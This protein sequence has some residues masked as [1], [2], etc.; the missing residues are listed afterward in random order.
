MIAND[1]TVLSPPLTTSSRSP[2][3][4][5]PP[6]EA[7]EVPAPSPPV[8]TSGADGQGAVARSLE[9]L[10]GVAGG[11]VGRLVDLGDGSEHCRDR[12]SRP[13]PVGRT[14]P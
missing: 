3:R 5:T 9:D 7:S 14:L 11:G 13:E 10:D 8:G 12:R 6:C 2:S 1:V 4:V